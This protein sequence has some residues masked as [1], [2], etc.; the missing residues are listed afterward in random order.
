MLD[1]GIPQVADP[2]FGPATE[3]AEHEFEIIRRSWKML[4]NH[5]DIVEWVACLVTG[6]NNA[7]RIKEIIS[8]SSLMILQGCSTR[9]P[10]YVGSSNVW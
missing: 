3:A 8:A 6:K 5:D 2:I 1:E 4:Q 7:E 10:P 9:I